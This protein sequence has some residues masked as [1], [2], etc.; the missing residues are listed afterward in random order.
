MAN[1]KKIDI[2][3]VATGGDQAA[4]EIK[5][6]GDAAASTNKAKV[7][8]SNDVVRRIEEE[9]KAQ[10]ALADAEREAAEQ[11]HFHQ[12][13]SGE[14]HIANG[15]RLREVALAA[16]AIGVAASAAATTLQSVRDAVNSVDTKELRRIDPAMADAI[17]STKNFSGWLDDPIGKLAALANGG[18]TVKEAFSAMNEQIALNAGAR[19]A[20]IDRIIA[21]GDEQVKAVELQTAALKRANELLEATD[22][23]NSSERDS[24]DAEAIRRGAAPED[25]AAQRAK[26]EAEKKIARINRETDE[27]N[28]GVQEAFNLAKQKRANV[29]TIRNT[30]GATGDDQRRAQEEATKAQKAADLRL[31]EAQNN[32]A[33]AAQQRRSVRVEAGETVRD[34]QFNKV[35]RLAEEKEKEAEKARNQIKKE[36]QAE[37]K[38]ANEAERNLAKGGRDR[39]ARTSEEGEIGRG[40]ASLL[41]K[42]VTKQFQDAVNRAAKGLQDG[43]QGGEIQTLLTLI[44]QLADAT[45]VKGTNTDTQIAALK[46]KISVMEKQFKNR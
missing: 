4:A 41:P 7:S 12:E 19:A 8:G 24:A 34:S 40:A 15:K 29:E 33:I 23:A 5:K 43:D 44:N 38:L 10:E 3:I 22:D 37:E 16:G 17:E 35:K 11:G 21:R 13:Q 42:G 46:Q 32:S 14:D 26:D 30:P 20:Q 27:K 39:D 36:D 9:T 45:Q 18:T 1:E 2:K 31:A 6:V 28:F 25:V